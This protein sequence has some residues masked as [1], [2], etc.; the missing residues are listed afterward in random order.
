MGVCGGGLKPV[1]LARNKP[2]LH[3]P[4]NYGIYDKRRLV[5]ASSQSNQDLGSPVKEC[6]GPFIVL[7]TCID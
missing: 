2:C 5:P 4:C 7:E 1:I 3:F 6:Y